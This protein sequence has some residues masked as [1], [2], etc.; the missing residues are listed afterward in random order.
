[1]CYSRQKPECETPGCEPVH[2]YSISKGQTRELT[3]LKRFRKGMFV[4]A[5][6]AEEAGSPRFC[7]ES[8]LE[9]SFLSRKKTKTNKKNNLQMYKCTTCPCLSSTCLKSHIQAFPGSSVVNSSANAG[10]MGLIPGSGR[11]H[12]LWRN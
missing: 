7:V 6:A 3:G 5:M 12:I 10:D 1:M 8:V 4:Q 9:L 2:S 11:F